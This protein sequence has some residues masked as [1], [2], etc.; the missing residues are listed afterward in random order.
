MKV[1]RGHR[2]QCRQHGRDIETIAPNAQN[3]RPVAIVLGVDA[4]QDLEHPVYSLHS[5]PGPADRARQLHLG[6]QSI[7][8][9]L[10]AGGLFD[11]Q[12][13]L[14]YRHQRT[15]QP[16]GQT[17]RQQREGALALRAIPASNAGSRR[18]QPLV[19]AV[20]GKT[21]TASRMQ[22]TVFQTC[23]TPCFAANVFLAGKPRLV[24]KL[25]NQPWPAR[26]LPWR[27]ALLLS[28][29]YRLAD[30]NPPCIARLCQ[31]CAK[32]NAAEYTGR[33]PSP[34]HCIHR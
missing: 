25:H 34:S 20:A 21:A 7:G 33:I 1:V 24:T 16:G 11:G 29:V 15:R 2:A 32:V 19:G 5:A 4:T 28:G 13:D 26:R 27:A 10:E 18:H 8:G 23:I 22:W 9:R 14:F 17:I 6:A 31:R 30:R 3:R 12:H